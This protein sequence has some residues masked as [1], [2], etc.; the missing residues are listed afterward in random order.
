MAK[1]CAHDRTLDAAHKLT[2]EYWIFTNLKF[3]FFVL[4]PKRNFH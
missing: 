4:G 1:L 3:F 2:G